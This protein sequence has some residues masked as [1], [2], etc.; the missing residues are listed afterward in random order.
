MV[1]TY[2]KLTGSVVATLFTSLA[3]ANAQQ[4]PPLEFV[5]ISDVGN[6]DTTLEET[7]QPG[8]VGTNVGSVSYEYAIAIREITVAEYF[9]F[10]QAYLPFYEARTGNAFGGFDFV[11]STILSANG[12]A[13]IRAQAA[14]DE[15]ADMGWAYAARYVNWLHNGKVVEEWAFETGVY[16]TSTFVANDDGVFQHQETRSPN[17]RYWLPSADE[18]VK[19][20]YWDPSGEGRYWRYPTTSDIEPIPGLLPEHG[21]ERNA[22]DYVPGV[23][24]W[25]LGVMS[26]DVMSPWGIYDM[27]GGVAEHSETICPPGFPELRA[28]YGTHHVYDHYGNANSHDLVGASGN[29]NATRVSSAVGLRIARTVVEPADLNRDGRVNFFDV[30]RFITDFINGAPEADLRPDSNY[31]QDDI[32][33]FLGLYASSA[34]R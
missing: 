29:T 25:P 22:G 30:A 21:G 23:M 1:R 13:F 3:Q 10:V 27:S 11:G 19:A 7:R 5:V 14:I 26:F 20:A 16:D 33:V 17:A 28:A 4:T 31:N 24:R 9:E 6:R 18:W 12:F 32:R 2:S 34:T 15:P 8:W